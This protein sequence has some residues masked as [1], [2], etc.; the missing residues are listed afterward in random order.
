MELKSLKSKLAEQARSVFAR[1]SGKSSAPT[2]SA[3]NDEAAL[4]FAFTDP[5][6]ILFPGDEDSGDSPAALPL[7][8]LLERSAHNIVIH[9]RDL[10]DRT[11]VLVDSIGARAG[12]EVTLATQSL[13]FIIGGVWLLTAI[14][15]YLSGSGALSGSLS[16]IS[17]GMPAEEA[18]TL[19]RTFLPIGI[20]GI[21]VAMAVA[22]LVAATGN[23]A[24]DKVRREAHDLGLFIA[25]T[26]REFDNDLTHM[27][28][29]MNRRGN[30]ADAVVDLSHAHLTALEAT[31]YFREISFLTGT[32]GEDAKLRFR[33]FLSRPSAGGSTIGGFLLGL[34]AGAI[35][36]TMFAGPKPELPVVSALPDI[37]KY[38]WAANLLLFGGILYALAGAIL[39]IAGGA[40][41][42]GAVSKARD[43]ALDSLRGAFTSREAPRP[44]D[45]IRRIEDAVDVFRARVGGRA[46]GAARSA[47]N[48][49]A[50]AT[51]DH[52]GDGDDIPAWRKRDSS[53][54]FV[55]TSFQAAPQTWR[56]DAYAKKFKGDD[57]EK[58]GSKR[59]LLGLKKP[60]RD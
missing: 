48:G 35:I 3:N 5:T 49:P 30:P 53:A 16:A 36:V 52:N 9:A 39:S 44:A 18:M 58:T 41:S 11:N 32:E 60:P 13:R 19:A 25:E 14:W 4:R 26:A 51:F 47:Q 27:R 29:E 7:S 12:G 37:A 34:A 17:S 10:R 22:A 38:P 1:V 54:Q 50:A 15:L 55:E 46:V 20:A 6:N 42:A 33:H 2:T 43:E 57:P 21:G 28:E 59:G 56:A 23:G 31:A 8:M 40:I 24:N 45:V